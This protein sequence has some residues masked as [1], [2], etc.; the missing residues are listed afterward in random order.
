SGP[1]RPAHDP[2][3][4]GRSCRSGAAAPR[5][6]RP[7]RLPSRGSSPTASRPPHRPSPWLGMIRARGGRITWSFG[8][9]GPVRGLPPSPARDRLY[10]ELAAAAAPAPPAAPT[11]VPGGSRPMARA[12]ARSAKDQSFVDFVLDQLGSLGGLRS[13]AMF[14]GHGIYRGEDFFGIV[15]RG[16]LFFKTGDGNRAA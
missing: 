15:H 9:Q 16:R 6:E 10:S 3:G 12:R 4:S 13:R 14:G 7:S 1:P 8:R 11:L 5:R 2:P